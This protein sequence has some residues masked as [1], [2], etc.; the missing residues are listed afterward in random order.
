MF[1][2]KNATNTDVCKNV[3][4]AVTCGDAELYTANLT[5]QCQ[6]IFSNANEITDKLQLEKY[7]QVKASDLTGNY[8]TTYATVQQTKTSVTVDV[9]LVSFS[10]VD[11]R[12]DPFED[13]TPIAEPVEEPQVVEET[14]DDSR[15]P[16]PVWVWILCLLIFLLLLILAL[17]IAYLVHDEKKRRMNK[18][19]DVIKNAAKT[20]GN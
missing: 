19:K 13:E 10:Y 18:G 5:D 11:K 12:D 15:K 7:Y 4:I 9:R 6:A 17:L 8:R 16:V 20:L 2:A 1:D 3:S 14:S